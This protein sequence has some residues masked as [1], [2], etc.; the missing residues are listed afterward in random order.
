MVTVLPEK[1]VLH[2]PHYAWNGTAL[3]P[4][5]VAAFIAGLHLTAYYTQ[6]VTGHYHGRQYPETL[7][8]LFCSDAA[9]VISSFTQAFRAGAMRQEAFA[10]ERGGQMYVVDLKAGQ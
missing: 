5:D 3:E 8:T 2:I 4:L 7:L 9:G 10:Y 6:T 1:L